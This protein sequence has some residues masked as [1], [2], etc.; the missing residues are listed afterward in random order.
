MQVRRIILA[1]AI[2]V[3]NLGYSQG[4]NFHLGPFD[5]QFGLNWPD[6]ES[7]YPAE[8][9]FLNE[10][11]CYAITNQK[12][13]SV[14]VRGKEQVGENGWKT[15]E[16]AI[17]I[18]PY[19]FGLNKSGN[20]ILRGSIVKEKMIREVTVKYGDEP[21]EALPEVK[22]EREKTGF[23][24]G[25]FKRKQ[26]NKVETINIQGFSNIQ[27]IEDSHVNVPE[28]VGDIFRGDIVR[29]I[30]QMP[31]PDNQSSLSN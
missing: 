23:F 12:Q 6:Y 9:S 4:F 21:S 2:L 29:V 26:E 15:V 5:L 27:V 31:L 11:I 1:G 7:A 3:S 25:L 22:K 14:I 24:S 8:G 17:T 13:L 19:V 10:P 28:N 18:E 30:C 20:P 16:K